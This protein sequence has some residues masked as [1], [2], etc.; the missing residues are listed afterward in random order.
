MFHQFFIQSYHQETYEISYWYWSYHVVI[1]NKI[2]RRLTCHSVVTCAPYFCGS[3]MLN[4]SCYM[5]LVPMNSAHR[6]RGGGVRKCNND[7]W[8][9]HPP[10]Q[11]S[12]GVL[13]PPVS[14]SI[15]SVDLYLEKYRVVKLTQLWWFYAIYSFLVCPS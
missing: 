14:S 12:P 5:D 6:L 2:G 11:I 8:D 4:S 9:P 3:N 13:A 7:K 10:K 1:I 15:T